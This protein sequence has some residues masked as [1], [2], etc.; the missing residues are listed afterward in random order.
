M[1]PGLTSPGAV[2]AEAEAGDVVVRTPGPQQA[3]VR[4]PRP[5]TAVAQGIFA[6]GKQHA[7]AVGIMKM[8]SAQM[9][10]A[11]PPRAAAHGRHL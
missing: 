10:A 11:R 4:L 3:R 5:L 7:M 9:C 1:C 8:S 6:E 2:M